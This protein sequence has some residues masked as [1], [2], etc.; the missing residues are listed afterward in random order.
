[1]TLSKRSNGIYY[2]W[3]HDESGKRRKVSTGCT[4]KSDALRFVRELTRKPP[5]QRMRLSEFASTYS[6]YSVG[7]HTKKT[8][9]GALLAL[10]QLERIVGDVYLDYL[11]VR[12]IEVF[13]A[14]KQKEASDWTARK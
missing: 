9:E 6:D 5:P 13:L 11:S 3:Y 4:R 1:M 10:S 8:H 12:Q 2:L 14:T 7:V